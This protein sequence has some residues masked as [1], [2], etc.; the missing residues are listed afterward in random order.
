MNNTF[1][2]KRFALLVK[3]AIVE[4]PLQT[5]GVMVLSLL[6]SFI[7]YV[8]IKR[9]FGFGAA[10]NLTLVWGLAGG[11]CFFSSFVFAH[12]SSNASGSS[13]LLLPASWL[14]KWL[15]GILMVGFMYPLIFLLCFHVMDLA[16]VA[17]YHHSLDPTSVFYRQQYESVYPYDLNDF[18][19]RNVYCLFLIL[20]GSMLTGSLYFNKIPFIKTSIAL[21]ILVFLL[22][23][24]NWLIAA[25]LF[26][27]MKDAAPFDHVTVAVG[28]EEGTLI[29]PT[30]VESF[31]HYSFVYAIPTIL[32][33]L[34]L[35]R[36]RE[37]EF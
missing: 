31:F 32:W 14:E 7:L 29:L 9:I 8:V 26:D 35:G 21:C 18:I 30:G 10:Q 19:A 22:F 13:Y 25:T 16:F 20:A 11:G 27:H 36:L 6:L 23:G 17:Q 28:K 5:I 33:T 12:F 1:N 24:L 15:C 34:P 2:I 4:R 3:K 37:K